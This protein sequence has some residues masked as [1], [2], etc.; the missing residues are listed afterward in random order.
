M[1]HAAAW[2]TYGSGNPVFTFP[3][4]VSDPDAFDPTGYFARQA[5]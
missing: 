5:S 4:R 2:F 3:D 1:P